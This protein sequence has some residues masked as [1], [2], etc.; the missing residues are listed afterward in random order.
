MRRM[1][2]HLPAILS[3]FWLA[4]SAAQAAVPATRPAAAPADAPTTRPAPATAPAAVPSEPARPVDAPA[5]LA[6][7]TVTAPGGSESAQPTIR[8]QFDG[9]PYARV[10]KRFA[11]MSGRPLIGDVNVEGTLTFFD[12][13]PY[14]YAEAFD[15]LNLLLSMRGYTL[16]AR[17]SPERSR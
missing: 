13:E 14:T 11:E 3:G 12:S 8:F 10:V 16:R 5:P 2:K 6:S 7:A 9:V 1:Q 4:V 17:S 15:A